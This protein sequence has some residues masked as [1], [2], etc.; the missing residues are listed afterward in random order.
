MSAVL[1]VVAAG[2]GAAAWMAAGL[3]VT[4]LSIAALLALMAGAAGLALP[5]GQAEAAGVA[6]ALVLPAVV[7][8][9]GIGRVVL[10]YAE[11][12]VTHAATFRFLAALRVWLFRGL[13]ERSAG[14]LGMRR[15]GDM[16]SRLVG[17]VEA[18]DGLYMRI[19]LP[20]AA[21]VLLAPVLVLAVLP[22]GLVP[23][24]VVGALFVAAALALPAL[25]ARS[26]MRHGLR[27]AEASGGLR[28]AALDALDGL[29]EVLAF[30]AQNRTLATLGA[31]EDA[32]ISAQRV[33]AKRAAL[34]QAGAFLCSQAALLVV[35]LSGS[36]ISVPAVFVCL[37]AFEVV[38][39]MPRAGVLAGYAAGAA[40]RIAAAAEPDPALARPAPIGQQ[41]IGTGLRFEAV[42]FRWRPDRPMVLDGL[43]LDIPAGSRVAVLGPSGSG[44]STLVSL[45][46]GVAHPRSGRVLLGGADMA[47][48]SAPDIR[49]RM[50]WL[51][52]NTHIFRDTVR[53][54]LLLGRPDASD[55]ALW[56]ALE[57]AQVAH[58]IRT[59][60]G[61]LDAIL[62]ATGLS[63]GE[64]RRVALA[65]TLVSEAPILLLD[66]PTAGLDA[67]TEL[68]FFQTL[69]T[70]AQG[71]TVVLIVHRLTGVEQLDRIWRLTAG[72]AVAA[73]A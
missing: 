59:L 43:T 27:L 34:A 37:A 13:A 24:A 1:K 40:Q 2:Q 63:G 48:L 3:L 10:R 31:K 45:A 39:G 36:P 44:K 42:Q 12:M 26:T 65:R 57:Q 6:A 21:A 52:Q 30:G 11:R 38:S 46:L 51:G 55:D 62:G 70:V 18:L 4:L 28:T 61:G 41:P 7:R 71:R 15:S 23:A 33:I 60:P 5:S 8:G 50:A 29:R 56:L 64:S 14:G 9:L 58:R 54:N 17:D 72:H 67:S 25:A 20:G 68:A 53:A 49:S 32:L 16:L 66:E 73:A 19:A 22:S 35:M 69:N 47:H